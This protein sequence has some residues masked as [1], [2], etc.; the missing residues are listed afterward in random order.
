MLISNSAAHIKAAIA[1]RLMPVCNEISTQVSQSKCI[2]HVHNSTRKRIF[3]III[4]TINKGNQ[5]EN[6]A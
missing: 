5:F 3:G 4:S 6:I 1:S 2:E